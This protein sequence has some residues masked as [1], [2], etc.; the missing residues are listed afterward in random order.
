MSVK[1]DP[2]VISRVLTPGF[3][4]RLQHTHASY[5]MQ[6]TL[7]KYMGQDGI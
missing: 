5:N 3:D 7:R 4:V 1:I 2:V 6:K